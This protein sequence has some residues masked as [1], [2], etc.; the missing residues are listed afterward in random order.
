MTDR[1]TSDSVFNWLAFYL[2]LLPSLFIH[3]VFVSFV[4]CL[5][6]LSNH[7]PQHILYQNDTDFDAIRLCT[8]VHD[9]VST[10]YKTKANT[11]KDRK[12]W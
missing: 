6:G 11:Q 2:S 9:H 3:L 12:I 1:H 7:R 5:I 4:G 10:P 8:H